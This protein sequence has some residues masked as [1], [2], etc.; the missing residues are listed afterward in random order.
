MAEE[1]AHAT[2]YQGKPAD[3]I[4]GMWIEQMARATK[5]ESDARQQ[6]EIA[7][8]C[9]RDKDA[10]EEKVEQLEKYG[11]TNQHIA[12]TNRE[13]YEQASQRIKELETERHDVFVPLANAVR[14]VLPPAN[15]CYDQVALASRRI[16][17]QD[18]R[19]AEMEADIVQGA[20]ELL[21]PVPAPGTDM[22]KAIRAV[23]VLKSRVRELEAENAGI[24]KWVNENCKLTGASPELTAIQKVI[25]HVA[26]LEDSRAVAVN[27]ARMNLSD[28]MQ[29]RVNLTLAQ[30]QKAAAVKQRT[31][32]C[33]AIVGSLM[34]RYS[35]AY[36][37]NGEVAQKLILELNNPP[38]S[39]YPFGLDRSGKQCQ[40][41]K[42][43]TGIYQRTAEN[44]E[45]EYL[46]TWD[47]FCRVCGAKRVKVA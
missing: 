9:R 47:Q 25:A 38:S 15:T 18:R 28:L 32:E 8:R 19:I 39:S 44:G 21:V 11:R 26:T 37:I 46:R 14:N 20:G 36:L 10:A 23:A 34:H 33:A 3:E 22:A 6:A 30:E 45:T 35:N 7:E 27:A 40:C 42:S 24:C 43:P 5:Y 13:L 41:W 4:A 1:I 31:V 12:E 16:V 29:A 2:R 17:E